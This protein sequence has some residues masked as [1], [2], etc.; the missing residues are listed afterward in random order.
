MRDRVAIPSNPKFKDFTGKIVNG[1]TVLFYVGTQG[2]NSCWRVRC[3]CGSERD[4]KAPNLAR[5]KGCRCIAS[6]R[7]TRVNYIHGATTKSSSTPEHMTWSGIIERCDPQKAH[8]YP[9]YAGR[10]ISVCDRWKNGDGARSGFE[11]FLADMGIR[12]SKQHS[13][14]RINNDGNYE[15][16]NCRWAT[17][18]EQQRNRSSNHYVTVL[19]RKVT[20]REACE[21]YGIKENTVHG[22]IKLGW[23]VEDA[24]RRPLRGDA[25]SAFKTALD[26][27]SFNPEIQDGDH[28]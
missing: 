23:S 7:L 19:G 8:S 26:R 12:P 16:G 22:R 9:R 21:M 27:P 25:A 20:L 3:H 17:M 10:G 11:C 28:E 18:V 24:L 14:D 4:V 2:G 5:S 6:A 1:Q 15:P 13:I